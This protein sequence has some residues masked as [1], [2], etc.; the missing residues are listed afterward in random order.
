MLGAIAA[1]AV[2]LAEADAGAFYAYDEGAQMFRLQATHELDPD[3]VQATTRRP[4]RLGQGAT[5]LAGLRRA[6]VQIPD[7]DQEA[8]Y[9][10]YDTIRGPGYR[11]LPRRHCRA[12]T[13]WWARW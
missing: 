7:I 5:G 9:A 13:A 11:A 8:G 6:A 12:R 1:H 2:K 3:V 4:V 10:F